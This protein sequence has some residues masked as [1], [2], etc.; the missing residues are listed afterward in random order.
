M[1]VDERRRS[2]LF[3]AASEAFGEE[4]AATMFELLPP[5]GVDVATKDDIDQLGQRLDGRIA[6]L[7]QRLDGRIDGLEQRI[8]GLGQ[9]VD[10]L[11]QRLD[12]RIDGLEQRLD[13]RIDGL[14]QRVDDRFEAQNRELDA[15]FAAVD[16]RL[17]RLRDEVVATFRGEL[18]AAVS[19][20]TRAIIVAVATAMFGLGGLALSLAQLF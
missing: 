7:G 4:P 20:Q 19:G 6:R 14:E 8:D 1:A 18:V 16:A 2:E 11:E 9:R 17:D 10:G 15:R 13:G 3:R 12:A 5:A